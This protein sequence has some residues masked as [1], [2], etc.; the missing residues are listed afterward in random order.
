MGASRLDRSSRTQTERGLQSLPLPPLAS[1]S[2]ALFIDFDGTLVDIV[3]RPD[4]VQVAPELP[5]LLA[6]AVDALDGAV[7]IVSGR[8]VAALQDWLPVPGLSFV[9]QHGVEWQLAGGPLQ[10]APLPTD[11]ETRLDEATRQMAAAVPELRLER[12]SFSSALHWREHPQRGAEAMAAA[13]AAAQAFGLALQPGHMVAEVKLPGIDKG[14]AIQRLLQAAP[15]AGRAPV[16]IGD[17]RTDETMF[18]ALAAVPGSLSI[19]V[20]AVPAEGSAAAYGLA[21]PTDVR[22]W[23]DGSRRTWSATG[24]AA[25]KKGQ[26]Q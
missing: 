23:L 22:G 21:T 16:A 11:F 12:K 9:G 19:R 3:L 17:D 24:A 4:D 8:P 20:G 1:D 13:S 10:R 2:A 15:F 18:A 26:A 25:V 5:D 6:Q 14:R 7:A